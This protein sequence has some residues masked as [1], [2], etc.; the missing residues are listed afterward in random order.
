M[1]GK[2]TILGVIQA[3]SLRDIVNMVNNYNQHHTSAPILKDDIVD[4]VQ[5]NGTYLLLYFY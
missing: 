1:E 3:Q 2:K 5:D 4:L